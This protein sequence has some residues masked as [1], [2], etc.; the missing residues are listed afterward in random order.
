MIG[1]GRIGTQ[2]ARVIIGLALVLAVGTLAGARGARAE[3]VASIRLPEGIP[4]LPEVTIPTL[5][6]PPPLNG[7]WAKPDYRPLGVQ[8]DNYN[9]THAQIEAAASTGCRLVRLPIPMEHFLADAEP[10]WA[11]LDQ[12]VSRLSREGFEILPVLTAKVAVPEFYPDFCAAVAKRYGRTFEYYQLL[13]NINYKIGLGT[14]DYA[15]LLSMARAAIV[16]ADRDAKIVAGGVRGC[17]LTYLDMLEQ[18]GAMRAIDVIALNLYPPK[19]GIESAASGSMAEH[20]LP[21]AGY[22]V[23]WAQQR[24]KRVWVTS[25]G[26]STSLNW[27]GVD[28]A[29]QA[30]IYARGALY[31][32]WLGVE[33]IIFAE[34]QDTDPSGERPA[35]CCGLLDVSGAPKASYYVLRSLNQA[36]NG[37]YH[38]RLPFA[39]QGFTFQQPE[40]EDLWIAAE[41]ADVPGANAIE[42]FQVHGLKIFTFWFYQPQ[43]EEYLLIYW[44]A[45]EPMYPTLLT[46]SLGHIGLTPEERYMLLDNAPSPVTFYPAQNFLYLPY[47]PV[48]TIP[49]VIKFEV[50]ENGRS[51]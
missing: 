2:S 41:L 46:L 39:Y 35:E 19:H 24:G 11:V 49:G 1:I 18:Q 40:A 28:Q 48:S 32:G 16:L 27:I 14:R 20:S 42:Q 13:D 36:I 23:D 8:L 31:L 33:H 22:V 12:V 26:V 15:D 51:G 34:I 17:D 5:I 6:N 7:A 50:N 47:Q 3:P 4:D 21:Y 38:I 29:E 25:L 45:D 9:L 10:D 30:A 44:L 37:A 43:T